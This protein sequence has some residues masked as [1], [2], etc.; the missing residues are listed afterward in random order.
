M[1]LI[2][3]VAAIIVAI[4]IFTW[5]INIVKVTLQTAFIVAAIVLL[6]AFFGIGPAQLLQEVGQIFQNLWKMITGK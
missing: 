5:L 4:L 6:L 2:L 3:L 1:N